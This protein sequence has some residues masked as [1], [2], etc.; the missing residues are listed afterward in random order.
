MKQFFITVAGVF[1]GMFLFVAFFLVFVPILIGIII[2]SAAGGE[3]G[4]AMASAIVLELDLRRSMTDQ[5]QA[6]PF[7]FSS[8]P[9]L[10]DFVRAMEA[11]E[12]DSRVRGV[13]IRV[14]EAGLPPAQAQEVG[15]A[16]RGLRRAGKFVVAH[17]QG[18]AGTSVLPYLAVSAADEIWLQ[19]TAHF[20][21]SG[22][23][24]ETTF[25]GGLIEHFDAQAQVLQ[26]AE[27]KTG[28]N[29]Y[30]QSG[31]TQPHRESLTALLNTIYDQSVERIAVDR[32]LT[33]D[34]V[35]ALLGGAPYSPEDA[36]R[37]GLIDRVGHVSEAR[38]AVERRADGADFVKLT[39]YL[40]GMSNPWN[41]GP[42][43]A[44]IA[45]QGDIMTGESWG[46][47]GLLSGGERIGSDT[48][49]QAFED[50]AEDDNVRAILFR[51]DTPGGEVVA[52]EQIWHAM[53]RARDAGK[54][55][56][57]SMGATAASGGYYVAAPAD[58]IIAQ[59]GTLTGSI[60]IYGGKLV[61]GGAL[62]LIGLNIEPLSIGGDFAGAYTVQRPFTEAQLQAVQT[63]LQDGYDTFTAHVAEGRDLSAQRVEQIARGR[64]WTGA[65]AF[66]LGLVDELGG[67]REAL[68]AAR[69]LGGI[70]EGAA[71]T[72]RAYPPRPSFFEQLRRLFGGGAEA[73]EAV[74]VL[75]RV[76]ALPEIRALIEARAGAGQPAAD[77]R[78]DMPAIR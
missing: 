62:D 36:A 58:A 60:G 48:V 75:L 24:S 37:A 31:F 20:T 49:A 50:A 44:L 18:F 26:I 52:S 34:E 57:V 11:A 53:Q 45:G 15:D 70:E 55:V 38:E 32:G 68:A 7:A 59:P 46:Q 27:Y 56:V 54:P 65:E 33:P 64:V 19:Q 78:A 3:R 41:S 12:H 23:S 42:T 47:D 17:S 21:V 74:S 39:D 4:P 2:A 28:A 10:L 8:A 51:L 40:R 13:F 6:N 22:V 1:T 35:R 29:T 63:M 67:F 76:A 5:P 14:G 69:R 73:A 66:E 9:S 77:A 25:F 16:I 71:I 72:L 30:T 43:I 61:I